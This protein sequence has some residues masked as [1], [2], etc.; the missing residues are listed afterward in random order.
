MNTPRRALA[1]AFMSLAAARGH[2][3][4]VNALAAVIISEKRTREVGLIVQEIARELFA[5]KKELHATVTSAHPLSAELKKTITALL[6]KRSAATSVHATY[7]V[8]PALKGGFV[9]RTPQGE[10]NASIA[11]QLSTLNHIV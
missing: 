1:K 7:A 11:H 3:H 2:D 5:Q 9:A 10:I 4:A 6:K 8:D